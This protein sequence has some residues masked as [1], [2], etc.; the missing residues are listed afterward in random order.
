MS[1]NLKYNSSLKPLTRELRKEGTKGEALLWKKVLRARSMGNYQFNRQYPIGDYIV[2]F[3]CR[4]LKLVIEIDGSSHLMKGQE[5]RKR[6]DDLERGGFKILRFTENE[7]VYRIDDVI[8]DI[9]VAIKAL[10]EK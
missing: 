4:K 2:D 7:V 3:I 6:Q 5:D 8:K 9:Y 1:D 10:E